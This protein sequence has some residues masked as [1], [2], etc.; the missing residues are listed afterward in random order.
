[1]KYQFY[2][3]SYVDHVLVAYIC[4]HKIFFNIYFYEQMFF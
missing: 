1:M 2:F 4:I 3:L